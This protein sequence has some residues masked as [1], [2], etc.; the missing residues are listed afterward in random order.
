MKVAELLQDAVGNLQRQAEE[1]PDSATVH[2]L[3]AALQAQQ[4]VA[5]TESKKL[6]NA[7]FLQQSLRNAATAV[8]TVKG[9]KD[10]LQDVYKQL[11]GVQAAWDERTL[12]EMESTKLL[13]GVLN[14][15]ISVQEV[16]EGVLANRTSKASLLQEVAQK[17][18]T[19]AHATQG[20]EKEKLASQAQMESMREGLVAEKQA[21]QEAL[22]AEKQAASLMRDAFVAKEQAIVQEAS[23]KLQA[24]EAQVQQLWHHLQ[25]AQQELSSRSTHAAALSQVSRSLEVQLGNLGQQLS[26][27]RSISQ[28]PPPLQL[29]AISPQFQDSTPNLQGGML[30]NVQA[31]PA[32]SFGLQ[33]PGEAVVPAPSFLRDMGRFSD[34]PL[35]RP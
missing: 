35:A 10:E 24:S 23:S 4:A 1:N 12:W 3:K 30:E 27:F 15:T 8:L 34:V 29:P 20:L 32:A 25:N 9:A 2:S 33:S 17:M 22:K 13:E 11:R 31:V 6:Q 28:E 19:V 7:A 21:S 16:V 14:D 18:R 5:L 26:S